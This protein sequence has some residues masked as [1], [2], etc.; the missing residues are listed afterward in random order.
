VTAP[1]P[2]SPIAWTRAPSLERLGVLIALT[3]TLLKAIVG[4]SGFPGWELDPFSLPAPASGLGPAGSMMCDT[5]IGLGVVL[6]MLARLLGGESLRLLDAAL[7]AI[8]A[9]GVLVHMFARSPSIADTWIGSS[10]LAA[11]MLALGAATVVP[12]HGPLSDRSCIE[13]QRGYFEWLV[14]EGTPR[15]EG[16]M[17]PLDA[18]RDLAGGPYAGWGE[19]ERLVVNLTALGR[20]LGLDPPAA[21]LTLFG[22][23]AALANG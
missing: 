10:W 11:M 20:D 18:A 23:M 7:F 22:G 6:M 1:A 8:G 3:A 17:A 12:G 14:A 21:V 16:G 15:L 5:A 4:I 19:G 13:D 9:A 2:H